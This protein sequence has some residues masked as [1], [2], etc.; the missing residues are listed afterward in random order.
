M[1][2]N[3][4][5]LRQIFFTGESIFPSYQYMNKGTGFV[6]NKKKIKSWQLKGRR[7]NNLTS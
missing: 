6:I 4:L 7:I 5:E 1:K 3:N 2:D